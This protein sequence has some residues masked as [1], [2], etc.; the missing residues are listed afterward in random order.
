MLI[1]D[2]ALYFEYE[3]RVKVEFESFKIQKK[4]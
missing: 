3:T 1:F 2:C 4:K